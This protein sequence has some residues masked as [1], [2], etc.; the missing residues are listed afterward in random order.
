VPVLKGT[1]SFST[2]FFLEE[3]ASFLT[4]GS[5]LATSVTS[6]AFFLDLAF[7]TSAGAAAG[8]FF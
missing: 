4:T 7:L 3:G 1:G 5:G 6:G 8:A 2:T